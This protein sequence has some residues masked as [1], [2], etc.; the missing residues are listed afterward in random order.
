MQE[1][2]G[3][4]ALRR[5]RVSQAGQIYLITTGTAG[6]EPLFEDFW[7]ARCVIRA[8]QAEAALAVTLAYV[9]MPDHLHW[10]IELAGTRSLSGVVG[11]MKSRASWLINQGCTQGSAV[12]AKGF[13]D[14][15]VRQE[16]SLTAIARYLVLNPVRAGLVKSSRDYPHWDAVWL[17]TSR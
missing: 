17:N 14:H 1:K 16:E 4:L 8:L 10:L 15:A 6:R 5:G 9:V 12:W 2:P 11:T 7:Q 13:H 3:T